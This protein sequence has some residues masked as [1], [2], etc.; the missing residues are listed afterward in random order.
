MCQHLSAA[1]ILFF[2]KLNPGAIGGWPGVAEATHVIFGIIDDTPAVFI[3]PVIVAATGKLI[4][5]YA[6]SGG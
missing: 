1:K 3:D 6:D 2:D 5:R 4:E